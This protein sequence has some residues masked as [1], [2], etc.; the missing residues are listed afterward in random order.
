VFPSGEYEDD[1]AGGLGECEAVDL[2]V[3]IACFLA[4]RMHLWSYSELAM[5]APCRV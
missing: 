3:V 5:L 1:G 4:R 2:A